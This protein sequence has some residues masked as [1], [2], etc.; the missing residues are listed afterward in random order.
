[1]PLLQVHSFPFRSELTGVYSGFDCAFQDKTQIALLVAW[2]SE[3]WLNEIS[4]LKER[5]EEG[6]GKLE[7]LQGNFRKF[8]QIPRVKVRAYVRT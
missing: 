7:A 8:L 3:L 6:R 2:L 4:R 5:G 1:M